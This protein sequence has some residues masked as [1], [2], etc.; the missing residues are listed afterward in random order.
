MTKNFLKANK[1]SCNIFNNAKYYCFDKTLAHS[2][3]VDG[4]DIDV[5]LVRGKNVSIIDYK[6][7][8]K[9][10]DNYITRQILSYAL[11][12][13]RRFDGNNMNLSKIG[14]YY[15][16]TAELKEIT[17]SSAIKKA[18]P[19]TAT[20]KKARKQLISS[21]SEYAEDCNAMEELRAI[22]R[23]KEKIW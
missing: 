13:D 15:V 23:L 2:K 16:R 9:P 14:I 17:L 5:A 18:F 19:S 4:A 8:L 22:S 20:L 21:F 10:I 7:I 11:L 12:W 3:A 6:T 1:P